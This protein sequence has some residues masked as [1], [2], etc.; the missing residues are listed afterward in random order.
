MI[1]AWTVRAFDISLLVSS[2]IATISGPS[3]ELK[4]S[5]VL[6]VV[7]GGVVVALGYNG[8]GLPG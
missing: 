5:V 3:S 7:I 2:D 6:C 1:D 8:L 4:L